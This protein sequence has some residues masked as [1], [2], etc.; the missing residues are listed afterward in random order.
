MHS[1]DA[2]RE[3]I[4]SCGIVISLVLSILSTDLELK[5]ASFSNDS[6]ARAS[7]SIPK[8][9]ATSAT[10]IDLAMRSDNQ[11]ARLTNCVHVT[12]YQTHSMINL[13]GSPDEKRQP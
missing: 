8:V 7:R 12:A 3:L 4:V 2:P 9:S 1:G 10:R 13:I 5:L 11:C 6:I